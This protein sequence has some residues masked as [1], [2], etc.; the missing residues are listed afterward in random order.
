MSG[1]RR[2]ALASAVIVLVIGLH[3]VP[4]ISSAERDTLWPF[5]V[6]SMYKHSRAAGPIEVHQRHFLA[7]TASGVRDTVTPELLGVSITVLTQ[8]YLRPLLTGD[9]TVVP[10]ILERLNRG[11]TDPYVEL[12]LVSETYTAT[13]TGLTRRENP[14]LIYRASEVSH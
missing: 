11:R 8:R 4:V 5:M 6:W 12:N 7:V 1:D 3:A 9:T 10:R 2:K 14:V 13:D